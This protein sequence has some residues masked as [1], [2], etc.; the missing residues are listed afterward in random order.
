[1]PARSLLVAT[2]VS[3]FVLLADAAPVLSGTLATASEVA[4]RI[5]AHDSPTA[6]RAGATILS[7]ACTE[8]GN[9]YPHVYVCKE[10]WRAR[11]GTRQCAADAFHYLRGRLTWAVQAWPCGARRPQLFAFPGDP[12]IART[13]F[14]HGL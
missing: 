13:A 11:D 2:A 14:V 12:A 3:F 9:A 5:Q 10:R 7:V 8:A 4:H 6:A 1:M